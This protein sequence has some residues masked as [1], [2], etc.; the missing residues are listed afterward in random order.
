M[1]KL[2]LDYDCDIIVPP[3]T[4]TDADRAAVSAY[5]AEY[6]KSPGYKKD[7]AA[8]HRTVERLER[9][10]SKAKARRAKKKTG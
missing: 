1:A 8:L 2:K 6:R 7:V 5:L 3:S 10:Q 9:A 4:Y